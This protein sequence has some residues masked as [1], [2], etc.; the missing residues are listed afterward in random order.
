MEGKYVQF[1]RARLV[2]SV[3]PLRRVVCDAWGVPALHA[4]G[5]GQRPCACIVDDPTP[6]CIYAA[7]GCRR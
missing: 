7:S 3:S 4:I 2:A 6:G 5:E 1:P